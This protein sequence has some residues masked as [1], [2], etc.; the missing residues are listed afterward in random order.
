MKISEIER[1]QGRLQPAREQLLTCLSTF[2][3]LGETV[4]S[5]HVLRNLAEISAVE[6][7]R[8]A[9]LAYFEECR[10]LYTQ[11]GYDRRRIEVER[12]LLVV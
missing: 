1:Q 10:S 5:A 4:G 7:D 6:G 11:L 8:Q 2:R 12:R 9:A 3:A